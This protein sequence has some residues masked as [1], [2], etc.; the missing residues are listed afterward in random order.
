[1]ISELLWELNLVMNKPYTFLK[2]LLRIENGKK[3]ME[4]EITRRN[5]KGI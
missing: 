2:I 4:T 5:G 3:H 1:M